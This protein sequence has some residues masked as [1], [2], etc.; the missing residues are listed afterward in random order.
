MINCIFN[1]IVFCVSRKF[2]I[3]T[4]NADLEFIIPFPLI[5]FILY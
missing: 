4:N 5:A 1:P 3:I 2:I